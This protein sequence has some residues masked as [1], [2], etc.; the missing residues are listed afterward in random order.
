MHQSINYFWRRFFHNLI[1]F[2]VT[3]VIG[4]KRKDVS[5]YGLELLTRT[6][7]YIDHN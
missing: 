4:L 2:H 6:K 1:S 3:L 7:D 5:E